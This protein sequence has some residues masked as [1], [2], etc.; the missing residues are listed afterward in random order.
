M[1]CRK[2]SGC[3]AGS[4]TEADLVNSRDPVSLCRKH[5]LRT[6]GP[7]QLLALLG[8]HAVGDVHV[9][10]DRLMMAVLKC[11]AVDNAC[12]PLSH[13]TAEARALAEL[14]GEE[15][16]SLVDEPLLVNFAR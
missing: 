4:E 15:L 2:D 8:L 11:F 7:D 16:L 1:E 5:F 3:Q 12:V 10:C 14:A 9:P 6:R 13:V